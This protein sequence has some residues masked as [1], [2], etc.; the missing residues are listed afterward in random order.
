MASACASDMRPLKR[1][2]KIDV[3]DHAE[4]LQIYATTDA[5]DLPTKILIKL[6]RTNDNKAAAELL[7][8]IR[9]SQVVLAD[10]G[11]DAE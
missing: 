2:I 3:L 10:R 8:G 5:E 7:T 6:G 4:A 9:N 11:Y 1:A